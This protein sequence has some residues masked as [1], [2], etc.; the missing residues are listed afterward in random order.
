MPKQ[1][2]HTLA[3]RVRFDKAVTKTEARNEAAFCINGEFHLGK[4]RTPAKY[5]A[6]KRIGTT[7]SPD[8]ALLA[9]AKQFEKT[10][11]YYVGKSKSDGDDEGSRMITANL[12]LVRATI[13]KAEGRR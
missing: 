6:V 3:M 10:I 11:E 12:N 7:Y 4:F 9:L 1:K 5:M 2:V 8:R 13:A